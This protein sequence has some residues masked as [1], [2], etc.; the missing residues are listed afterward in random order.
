MATHGEAPPWKAGKKRGTATAQATRGRSGSDPAPLLMTRATAVES[1]EEQEV[2][3]QGPTA[4]A[5][6]VSTKRKRASKVAKVPAG[7]GDNT[8]VRQPKA[9]S[10][11][12]VRNRRI[13]P[14][15]TAPPAE[16]QKPK[17]EEHQSKTAASISGGFM[18]RVRAHPE[19]LPRAPPL[20]GL[21]YFPRTLSSKPNT[22][23]SGGIGAAV[24]QMRTSELSRPVPQNPQPLYPP[25]NPASYT[26]QNP[27]HFAPQQYQT[28]F[29]AQTPYG[30]Q[31]SSYVTHSA[32]QT[33]SPYAIH[34]P[35]ATQSPYA[36][37]NPVS[38]YAPQTAQYATQS[39]YA[40]QHSPYA[41]QT[42]VPSFRPTNNA[43]NSFPPAHQIA[44]PNAG[45]MHQAPYTNTAV[46]SGNGPL[47][48]GQMQR[49]AESD[50]DD[51][52]PMLGYEDVFDIEMYE[53]YMGGNLEM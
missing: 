36:V 10:T 40:V 19:Q 2:V 13:A 44:N 22:L 32:Y 29:A 26:A 46:N 4:K 50:E 37:Q 1:E 21:E 52:D 28:P 12:A 9:K 38:P 25:Q 8:P 16:V 41:P 48:Q 35:Y 20:E 11:G 33:Q 47:M 17:V 3:S 39:P 53:D 31:T 27:S 42:G 30:T 14:A 45:G 7:A 34:T 49:I 18:E 23:T 5:K 15:P 43:S 24:A 51:D 6:T